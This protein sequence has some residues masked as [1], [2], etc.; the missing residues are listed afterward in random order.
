MM[1]IVDAPA[2][3]N[4]QPNRNDDS[5][6]RTLLRTPYPSVKRSDASHDMNVYLTNPNIYN[7]QPVMINMTS[8]KFPVEFHTTLD[9]QN[10][11]AITKHSNEK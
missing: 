5:Y 10:F 6:N 8:V 7:H 1:C 3:Y 4:T 9:I 11:W 2:M